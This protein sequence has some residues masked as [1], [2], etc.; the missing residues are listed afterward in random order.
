[1]SALQQLQ[2]WK[3]LRLFANLFLEV[4]LKGLAFPSVHTLLEKWTP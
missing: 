3:I 4:A 1:M 2:D